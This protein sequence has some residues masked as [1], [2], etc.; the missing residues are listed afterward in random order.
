MASHWTARYTRVL[1]AILLVMAAL[2]PV[3]GCIVQPWW[4]VKVSGSNGRIRTENGL[5]EIPDSITY[6]RIPEIVFGQPEWRQTYLAAV[7]D[8]G[9]EFDMWRVGAWGRSFTDAELEVGLP[10]RG[11][12]DVEVSFV[13]SATETNDCF[14][15][16]MDL[17][18]IGLSGSVDV[19]TTFAGMEDGEPDL[20]HPLCEQL[21]SD[22]SEC[23]RAGASLWWTFRAPD[24]GILRLTVYC[25]MA[26]A[27][28]IAVF[29][30]TTLSELATVVEPVSAWPTPVD[31]PVAEGDEMRIML[32][33]WTHFSG[34]QPSGAIAR[35][36]TTWEGVLRWDF[37]P[38]AGNLGEPP[39]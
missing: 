39:R 19:V 3:G 20:S 11:F 31:V 2:F 38:A 5:Y 24:A 30:G 18:E 6:H 7:P 29:T 25:P 33:G 28:A 37:V 34:W 10:K 27:C 14:A 35:G 12:I 32:D 26:G 23:D 13:P 22:L 9:F 8:C 21:G 1:R 15:T 16:P 17:T 36:P 4:G